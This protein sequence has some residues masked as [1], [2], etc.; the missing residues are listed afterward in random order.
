MNFV[1]AF[2]ESESWKVATVYF[3]KEVLEKIDRNWYMYILSRKF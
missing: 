2:E 3:V 1:G